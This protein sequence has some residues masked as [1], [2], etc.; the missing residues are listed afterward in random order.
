[1]VEVRWS[2]RQPLGRRAASLAVRAVTKLAV[3]LKKGLAASDGV[4]VRP[5]IAAHR[6]ILS[7]RRRPL[8]MA[9]R[10]VMMAAFRFAV[11]AVMAAFR[12]AV[13]AVMAM[14]GFRCRQRRDHAERQHHR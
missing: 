7:R 9:M 14:F 6:R 8:A 3:G 1:M 12:F 4:S 2:M 11:M 10:M 13:M 5:T